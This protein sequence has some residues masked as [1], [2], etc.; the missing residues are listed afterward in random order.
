MPQNNAFPERTTPRRSPPPAGP[1]PDADFRATFD[2]VDR[3][4]LWKVLKEKKLK[5]GM[6][7]RI[8]MIY[9]RT[10]VTVRTNDGLSGKFRTCKGVRQGCSESTVI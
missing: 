2:N 3:E 6:L 10:E 4:T 1:R 7:K 5:E 9:E 8:E